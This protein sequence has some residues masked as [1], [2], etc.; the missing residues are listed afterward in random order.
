MF[1]LKD[2]YMRIVMSLRGV[3]VVV[4]T[5]SSHTI[6][7]NNDSCKCLIKAQRV[8][9]NCKL[10]VIVV[11]PRLAVVKYSFHKQLANFF[12]TEH[13]TIAEVP[14]T[15][16]PELKKLGSKIVCDKIQSQQE[17]GV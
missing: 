3:A 6:Y 4:V 15:N 17:S 12:D 16:M 7:S 2:T 13:N 1:V 5:K 14:I 8:G 9:N 10:G 11:E